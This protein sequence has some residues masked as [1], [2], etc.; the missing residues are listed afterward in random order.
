MASKSAEVAFSDALKKQT[1]TTKTQVKQLVSQGA[2]RPGRVR[3]VLPGAGGCDRQ[4]HRQVRLR[5]RRASGADGGRRD[6]HRR[7]RGQD[8]QEQGQGPGHLEQPQGQEVARHHRRGRR[9]QHGVCRQADGR[10]RR[11]D[12]GHQPDRHADV[13][14]HVRAQDRQCRDLRA[15]SE[16]REVHRST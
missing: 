4:R 6:R 10:G 9:G 7:L 11:G 8:P 14:R 16:G 13:Q 12:A 3:V 2:C 5:Q 1:S 15:A